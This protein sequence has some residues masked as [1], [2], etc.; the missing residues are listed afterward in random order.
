MHEFVHLCQTM[1]TWQ[2]NELGIIKLLYNSSL[3]VVNSEHVI[4]YWVQDH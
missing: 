3:I 2:A 1:I 4:A